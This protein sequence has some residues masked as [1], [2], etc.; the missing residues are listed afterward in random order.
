MRS[1]NF[2]RAKQ[3]KDEV[4]SA[5][6]DDE[7]IKALENFKHVNAHKDRL[8]V[9]SVKPSIDLVKLSIPDSVS[10]YQNMD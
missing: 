2:E 8:S 6:W 4:R 5:R 9:T 1:N 10:P 7:F 3:Y